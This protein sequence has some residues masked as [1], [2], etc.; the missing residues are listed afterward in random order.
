[1]RMTRTERRRLQIMSTTIELYVPVA[2]LFTVFV[3]DRKDAS[4]G[5]VYK[6]YN[7]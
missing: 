4:T 3:I 5:T 2:K 6:A 7:E 1:M